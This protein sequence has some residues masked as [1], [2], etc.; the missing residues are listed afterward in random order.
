VEIHSAVRLSIA[1][2][3]VLSFVAA[4]DA[5]ARAQ[6][7]TIVSVPATGEWVDTGVN[8]QKG[9]L[10]VV[11]VLPRSPTETPVRPSGTGNYAETT[12]RT[13][14][15]PALAGRIG[16]VQFAVGRAY[17]G[18]AVASGELFL[19]VNARAGSYDSNVPPVRAGI[20][21][22]SK[23]S[24][25]PTAIPL[26]DF[27]GMK[28]RAAGKS[29][30]KLGLTP[31]RE[32]VDSSRPAGEIVSQRPQAGVDVRTI[33]I[34]VLEVSSG[35]APAG[36]EVPRMPN[37]V[38]RTR[39][40]AQKAVG[41]SRSIKP[42]F[43]S[44]PSNVPAGQVY[45]QIPAPGVDLRSVSAIEIYVSTGPPPAAPTAT[46]AR[47][48]V[49][50][51][52]TSNPGP[53]QAARPT[54]TTPATEAQRPPPPPS[55]PPTSLP[56]TLLPTT[57]PSVAPTNV[58][59]PVTAV[60]QVVGDAEGDA[61]ATIDRSNL[62]STKRGAEP[63]RLARGQVTRTDPVAG[64]ALKAG[65]FVG[66]WV[67]DGTNVVP[68]LVGRPTA[69]A[70]KM[71]R[72]S[73]FRL[74]TNLQQS[75]ADKRVAQQN[76]A[77]G[78]AVLLGSAVT[79]TVANPSTAWLVVLIPAGLLVV[80][81]GGLVVQRARLAKLTRSLLTIHPS[82]DLDG[83][84]KFSSDIRSAG[85]TVGI[86]ASLEPGALSTEETFPIVRHEVQDD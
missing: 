7:P 86:Q 11:R 40:D 10:F 20:Y 69:E 51:S 17:Q 8:L 85:P 81:L 2:L 72:E 24:P 64:S 23:A 57:L 34:V 84:T 73:G 16:S 19:R 77:A 15:A 21:R 22:V 26:P 18:E 46:P 44:G 58:P 43:I 5:P 39:G 50:A 29:L 60:P 54:P 13:S 27:V 33:K 49:T 37:V 76:P 48:T 53:T 67:A 25:T 31:Q 55:R 45:R 74:G 4:L 82:L 6:T 70:D 66:Y 56:T 62:G 65:S 14:P 9:E 63:S 28:F 42:T 35:P 75:D 61:V 52:P 79:I 12:S 59:A 47:P 36:P 78:T 1:L 71:L 41:A 38:G 68:D 3:A 32:N 83:P 80:V 30:A